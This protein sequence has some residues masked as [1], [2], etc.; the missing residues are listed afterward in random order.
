MHF[1]DLQGKFTIVQVDIQQLYVYCT[2]ESTRVP[3][4][5]VFEKFKNRADFAMLMRADY[6]DDTAL[7][8]I[9]SSCKMHA[10]EITRVLNLVGPYPSTSTVLSKDVNK[11][12][13]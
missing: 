1:C 3:V 8:H 5:P 9:S 12:Y 10:S 11:Y 4:S 7:F 6:G 2:K 13:T